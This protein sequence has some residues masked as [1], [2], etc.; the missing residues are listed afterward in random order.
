MIG[1]IKGDARSSAYSSSAYDKGVLILGAR[2]TQIQN[3]LVFK[4]G[5]YFEVLR[6][7]QIYPSSE[8]QTT[9]P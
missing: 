5:A 1:L 8:P 3:S 9:K 4:H 2:V 7:L 6:C